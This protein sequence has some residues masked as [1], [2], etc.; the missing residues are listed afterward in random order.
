[1]EINWPLKLLIIGYAFCASDYN[2]CGVL[3]KNKGML[4]FFAKQTPTCG[5]M[6]Y[7]LHDAALQAC[8]PN[9]GQGWHTSEAR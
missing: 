6:C 1:M 2:K 8:G 7:F 9:L 4:W 3:R 5:V